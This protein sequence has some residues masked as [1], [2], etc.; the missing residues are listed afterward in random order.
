VLGT[1]AQDARTLLGQQIDL[2]R[3]E[4]GQELRQAGR[5]AAEVAA[6]GGL[7]AAGGLMA[8]FTAVHLLHRFTGLPLWAC[9][10]LA[11]GGLGAAG[12]QLLRA[13]R[14]GFTTLRALP[15]T[16]EALS[17]N[18]EWLKEQLNPVGG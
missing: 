4:V 5:A 9:Y 15:Q 10:G 2:F 6:G 7:A 3:A 11:A 1:I 13:G 8:G 12:V 14:D 18:V 16:T 17:E